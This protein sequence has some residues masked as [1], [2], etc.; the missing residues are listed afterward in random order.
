[1]AGYSEYLDQ[2]TPSSESVCDS[3]DGV[4]AQEY[5]LKM[6]KRIKPV[7]GLDITMAALHRPSRDGSP[8]PDRNQSLVRKLERVSRYEDRL[9]RGQELAPAEMGILRKKA[10]YEQ[11]LSAMGEMEPG[12]MDTFAGDPSI[13]ASLARRQPANDV[14]PR[15]ITPVQREFLKKMDRQVDT[16]RSTSKSNIQQARGRSFGPVRRSPISG[17]PRW[18][19]SDCPRLHNSCCPRWHSSDRP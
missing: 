6:E 15:A 5:F 17:C 19:S 2:P 3:D 7:T 4:S 8:T 13:R 18:H 16:P 10:V 9:A 14:N 11:E 1:M 12:I